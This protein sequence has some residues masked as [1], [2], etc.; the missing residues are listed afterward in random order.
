MQVNSF[1]LLNS[2]LLVF[3]VDGK[4]VV[5]YKLNLSFGIKSRLLSEVQN[6]DLGSDMTIIECH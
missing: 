2:A 5:T 3:E 1:S 4:H 6:V